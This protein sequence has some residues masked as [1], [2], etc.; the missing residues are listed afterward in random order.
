MKTKNLLMA[1][2]AG[3]LA[4]ASCNQ[5]PK[6]PEGEFLIEGELK[7]VPDSV[8][9]E[10]LKEDGK[11]LITVKKDTI[12]KGAFSFR[13]TISGNLPQKYLLLSDA[14][15]F[16]GMWLD[17]WT[18]SGQYVKVKGEDKL[19]PLW[20]VSS[21]IPEQQYENEFKQLSLTERKES[22]RLS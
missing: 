1:F 7:N 18:A 13:D 4:L 5:T 14:D 17:V 8:V 15:G 2:L 3:G 6:V 9:I 16:P 22:L 19:L 10:L 20:N 12:I 21:K 11:L